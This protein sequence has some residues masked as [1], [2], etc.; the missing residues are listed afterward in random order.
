MAEV[1]EW[2]KY[3]NMT[4]KVNT[5]IRKKT[6]R[7]WRFVSMDTAIWTLQQRGAVLRRKKGEVKET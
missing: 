3:T 2:Q 4:V 1:L 5:Y 6:K 7:T